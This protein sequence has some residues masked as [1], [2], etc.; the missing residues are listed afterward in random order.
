MFLVSHYRNSISFQNFTLRVLLH[1]FTYTSG[2]SYS[3]PGMYEASDFRHQI[4][5]KYRNPCLC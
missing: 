4:V 5:W 1:T 2:T 3:G